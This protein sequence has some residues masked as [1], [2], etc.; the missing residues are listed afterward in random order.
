MFMIRPECGGDGFTL[1]IRDAEQR[2]EQGGRDPRALVA[3]LAGHDQD[4]FTFRAGAGGI[5]RPAGQRRRIAV[6]P[7]DRRAA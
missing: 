7:V 4:R 5:H 6:M 2:A 3:V 1:A